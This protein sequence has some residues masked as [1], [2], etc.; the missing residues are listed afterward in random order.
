MIRLSIRRPVAVAMAYGAVALLGVAAWRNIPIELL[1]DTQ[2]P[3]LKVTG[4]WRGASPETVEAFLTSPLESVIQQVKGVE[5]IT[6]DSYETNGVGTA[7]IDVEFSRD[8]D[9]DFAR[10]DLSERIATLEEE[11]PPGTERVVVEPY[12]PE[13]FQEQN[14]P[15]LSYTFTGPYTLEA[16]RQHVDD[17]IA[18]EIGQ[19]DGVGVVRV[20][21]G[22]KRRLEIELDEEKVAALDLDPA[23]VRAKIAALDMVREVGAV[24]GDGRQRTVTIVNR[25]ENA[26][27]VRDAVLMAVRGTLVRVG[28]VAT[29]HDRYEEAQSYYRINGRPAVSFQVTKEIGANTVRVADAVKKRLAELEG[30]NPYGTRLILDNDESKEIREQLSDLRTRA[31]FSALVIFVVLLAFLGSIRSAALIFATIAFSVL[32]ALNLI[33]FGGLT[34]N[35]LTLMG[36]AMGFGLIVDNAIV[37]L[38]NVYRRWR[39]GEDAPSAAEGGTREVVL[40][41]LAS[42][43]TTLIVFVPFVYLQ[44]ELRVFYV[45]LAVVVGLTLIASLFVAFTFIPSLASRILRRRGAGAGQ[46]EHRTTEEATPVTPPGEA[47]GASAAPPRRPLY[48]RF[49]ADVVGFTVRHPWA[50]FLV[51]AMAFGGSYHLFD[52]YVTTWAVFGGG[53]ST[54]TYI[55]VYITLP[56]GSNLDRTDELV[57][58]FEDKLARIP[59]VEQYTAQIRPMFAYMEIT[60]PDSLEN[61]Q[62]PVAIKEQMFAYSHSFTGAE[63]RVYGY[64]PSFYGGGS[65]PPNYAITVLGYNYERVRDI[66]EDIGRRLSRLARV[67]EVDTNA[68]SNRF[69]REKASEYVVTIDRDRLARH[70][71]TVEQLVARLQ[72]AVAGRQTASWLK[73]GGDEVQYQVKLAAS[74]DMDVLAL[75]ETLID[76]PSGRRIR[77]GDVVTITPREILARIHRE[78]QQYE[79]TVAYEFRGPQKLGDLWHDRVIEA[80]QVPPGYTVKKGDTYWWISRED[81]TQIWVTIAVAL[82]LVYMVTAALFESLLQPL[83]V[84]LTVPMALI[85]VYL[86]FFYTEASFTREA[87]VGVIMMFGIVV[88]NAILLVDHVNGVRRRNVDLSLDEAIVKGTLE[89]VRPILMTTATT[90]LGLL[91]LVVFGDP[92]GSN[93]WDALALVLIGGL[94]SST[95]FVLTITPAAYGVLEGWKAR[96][97]REVRPARPVVAGAVASGD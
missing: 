64:G 75:T 68:G 54:R 9:M 66:A 39:G 16:L 34:L 91:P 41:I 89:R 1:P 8:T 93:I 11:L 17:V 22:R 58:F 15:F 38:E 81:R 97:R 23:A 76:T 62:I 86:I 78:N 42:T 69:Q 40:P 51:T 50:A 19:V 30:L 12:V 94:L 56:R 87:Y 4:Q 5:K 20:A 53:L 73:L 84:I 21:G 29:V 14:R 28:D 49:Y 31:L 47:S 61:T 37:V 82:L 13:E 27:D 24:R 26:E 79:R 25:P 6:S 80:T 96:A 65:S 77:L 67:Q 83:C 36:L 74:A 90:V 44:G 33:Y 63:V 88:N 48:V 85:G 18:P 71:L 52:K 3:R 35:I 70:D 32:I 57:A 7:D 95:L 2:L 43:A 72:A 92:A 45:P 10:L 55:S 60:F 46:A 59:E